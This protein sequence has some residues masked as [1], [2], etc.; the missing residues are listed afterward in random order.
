MSLEHTF[1]GTWEIVCCTFEGKRELSGLEGI[2]FRL[3]DT[4]DITWYNDL[5]SPVPE[6]KDC[7]T[8]CDSASVLFS[9]ETFDVHETNPRLVFGAFAG[10]S[11]EFSTNT[12]TPTETLVLSCENW[13]AVECKRLQDG[14]AAGQEKQF[15]FGEALQ[16]TYFSDV[17]VKSGSGFEFALHA[18]I[19]R[20]NGFDCSMCAN[21]A[22]SLAT[23]T[24]QQQ[25]Q[26]QQQLRATP[27]KAT[28]NLTITPQSIRI[29]VASASVGGDIEQKISL[30][31]LN[32][33]PIY[34]QPPSDFQL[35]SRPALGHQFSSS[36][37]CLSNGNTQER[38][39]AEMDGIMGDHRGL[40]SV[41]TGSGSSLR[42]HSDSHLET[43]AQQQTSHCK[44][45]FNF[46]Q[47]L[48]L[49][50][51]QQQTSLQAATPLAPS[52]MGLA[53]C[54]TRRPP[55]SPYRAR[56]PS[57]F[58]SSL[59]TPPSSPLTPVGVLYNLPTF[60]LTPILHWLYTESLLPDLDEDVCEKLINFA[61]TQ[62]SL[63]KLVEPTRKYLRLMRLKKFVVNVTMD[64]HGILNRVIQCI[65]PVSISHEPA[66]LYATF[67]DALRECAIG[68][69]KVLQFCNIFIK[70]ASHMARYQ[71]NEIV[72]YVR[73]RIPI[74][75]SQMQQLL[76][77]VLGVFVGLSV[78]EKADLVNYLVPEIESTLLILTAV[79]EEIKNSLETMCKDL[80][81]SHLD[82]SMQQQQSDDAIAKQLQ[83]VDTGGG[84]VGGVAIRPRR[85]PPVGLTL[86]DNPTDKQR[87]SSTENDLK[88]VLY[89]YEVRKM[90]DIYGRIAA[91]LDI[92]KNK[93]KHF[94][95]MDFLSKRS[96]INQNLE[97]LI[98]DI[99][100]YIFIVENLSDRLDDK[101]GWKEFKFCFKLAT[102]QINGV[103]VKLL[104]HKSA[105]REAISQICT[106]VRKQEF[107][108]SLIELGLLEASNRL[109][110]DLK[111][112]DHENNLGLGVSDAETMCID[113][114]HYYDYKNIKLN[115]IR[116]LCEPPIA[117]NS[118]L[119][120]N[121]LRLLHSAQFADMEFEVH[122]YAP[123]AAS[124]EVL[125]AETQTQAQTQSEGAAHSSTGPTTVALQVHSFKAHRVIV[126][127]RCEWF[128]KALM[129]GMQESIN[130][131]VIITDTSPVIFRRLLLYLY[132]A[133]IDRTVGAEQI[134]E[135]MLLADR[136]SID[137]LKE[138]CENTLNS[139]I[140]EDSVVCLLGIADRYMAIALK[141]NCLSFLS[142]HAQLTKCE[143]FKELPQTLQLEVMDLIH[144][145]G[146][147]SEPWNDR[148]FKPRSSSRHSLKSPS[149]PRSRSR[150]SSPS[151]M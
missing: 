122:T 92:I 44:N 2:K 5:V 144:W 136:Y 37:N 118:N 59:D 12:L 70:D 74:F 133:P 65:N 93:K 67:Q 91:A 3:D 145:F 80:K 103:I 24:Q 50:Q 78:D 20:L 110:H 17:V 71:K 18:S 66:Q 75:M 19:L 140:D 49:Q 26:Q 43:G 55:L 88:F 109:Q 115:L 149:K 143:I 57:P 98:V 112:A 76:R 60:L 100:A 104:D 85:G 47:D 97:Q 13:Y 27:T 10:H 99:P 151:Y 4:S 86:Y 82:L 84:G 48:M 102:S 142:Q 72:K 108:Q 131:K 113:R 25:Q 51:Q 73:T 135:L 42:C 125:E 41:E 53:V 64:L 138:L 130:R 63:T 107:T 68:C 95:E 8:C 30:P 117:A 126:A 32:L 134:C 150:K 29:S 35:G 34:L 21:S 69:A 15:T 87:L 6:T 121:A 9:C 141:S 147:V 58:P 79:I 7:G 81:C 83:L 1:L 54:N 11:I 31:R 120:K 111:V 148:G 146:R 56:S 119:S 90:R 38:H 94:C 127:A 39:Q 129:S 16:E 101:L 139:L 77:N 33:S 106:L 105:L 22:P 46:C 116:H 36:F 132:G 45:I 114:K 124:A 23:S 62:P 89:M 128:K 96:T 61:E 14:Q 123:T 137:D 28:N 40:L 52:T